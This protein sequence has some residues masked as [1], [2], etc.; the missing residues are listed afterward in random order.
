[1]SPT[2]PSSPRS[3]PSYRRWAIIMAR[4]TLKRSLREA[5][6]WNL[7]VVN[8]AAGLRRRSR[9]STERTLQSA[10][11]AAALILAASSPFV[12]GVFSSPIPMNR[13][14]KGGGLAACKWA[15]IVQYSFLTN[16]LMSRS[17]S[18]IRRRATVCVHAEFGEGGRRRLR[19]R[20]GGV[21]GQVKLGMRL[22][23][24]GAG[25]RSDPGAPGRAHPVALGGALAASA[26]TVRGH[27]RTPGTVGHA[28]NSIDGSEV[29]CSTDVQRQRR[30]A[31][32]AALSAATGGQLARGSGGEDRRLESKT[33][34]RSLIPDRGPCRSPARGPGGTHPTGRRGLRA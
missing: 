7:L 23:A 1:M 13:A 21:Q 2:V 31:D 10:P 34:S 6:C 29:A 17:R 11:S 9:L 24:L 18:T 30:T 33:I 12:M 25:G 8:G 4:F 27:A 32:V 15:S 16:A 5:S 22:D 19:G 14:A 26:I 3:T 20:R 28:E